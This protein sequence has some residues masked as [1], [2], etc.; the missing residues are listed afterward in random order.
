MQ[1]ESNPV[2]IAFTWCIV[3]HSKDLAHTERLL[4][5]YLCVLELYTTVH[6]YESVLPV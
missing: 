6:V 5:M 3:L 2:I 4:L 1:M